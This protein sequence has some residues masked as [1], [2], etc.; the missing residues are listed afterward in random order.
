MVT[1][2]SPFSRDFGSEGS[3]FRLLLFGEHSGKQLEVA[4]HGD[5]MSLKMRAAQPPTACASTTVTGHLIDQPFAFAAASIQFP[6][7]KVLPILSSL[8]QLLFVRMQ[9]KLAAALTVSTA[10]LS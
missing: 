5:Q 10:A 1:A 6:D 7:P 2:A 9:S 3:A 4:P 8:T